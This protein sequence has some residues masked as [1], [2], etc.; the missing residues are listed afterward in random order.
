MKMKEI[1]IAVKTGINRE[2]IWAK[3]RPSLGATRILLSDSN[4]DYPFDCPLVDSDREIR[5]EL[6]EALTDAPT[7][8]IDLVVE[9]GALLQST[10]M[11]GSV[12]V[13]HL[14]DAIGT[15][16]VV[17]VT[18]DGGRREIWSADM[19]SDDTELMDTEVI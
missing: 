16:R 8:T 10:D 13:Q 1:D 2:V 12:M 7:K 11:A 3:V 6:L 4:P 14:I 17:L 18:P 5:R 15:T 9:E 19:E